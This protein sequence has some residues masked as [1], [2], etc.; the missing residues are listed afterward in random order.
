MKI[1]FIP[2]KFDPKKVV[3]LLLD[4]RCIV[5]AFSLYI[6]IVLRKGK[7][8]SPWSPY[9][10]DSETLPLASV[11]LLFE[12]GNEQAGCY[13]LDYSPGSIRYCVDPWR[14]SI[15]LSLISFHGNSCTWTPLI[16]SYPDSKRRG[17]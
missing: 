10:P 5:S 14:N 9:D 16:L 6:T 2:L 15:T 1:V 17:K 11:R 4:H 8:A 13:L 3:L 7:L 12:P